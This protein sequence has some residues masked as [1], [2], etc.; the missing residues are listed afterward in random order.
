[1][2][3]TMLLLIL[4]LP[5]NS[6]AGDATLSWDPPTT[7]TDGTPLTDLAGYIIY[8]GTT[9]GD[10]SQSVDAGNVTTSQVANL[11]DGITYYFA[12]TAYDTSWNESDYS[13]EISKAIDGKAYDLDNDG[14][15]D[16]VDIMLV[17]VCWNTSIGDQN[18]NALYDFD[19]D[20]D[21]DI[22]DIMKVRSTV[23]LDTVN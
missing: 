11:T 8:Y 14:D 6:F 3:L 19:N 20:G 5:V 21:I 4:L 1:M 10:Y 9:T 12:V 13:N 17:A 18:Y 7:N 15:V 2:K 23:G 16:I 22:V